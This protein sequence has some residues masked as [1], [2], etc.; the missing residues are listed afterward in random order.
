[1]FNRQFSHVEEICEQDKLVEQRFNPNFLSD[2]P[3]KKVLNTKSL[4]PITF[5]I[6]R[7]VLCDE[8]CLDAEYE[9]GGLQQRA[10]K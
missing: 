4:K 9:Q 3:A 7:F 5:G 1:M 2:Q 6:D 8:A 10:T